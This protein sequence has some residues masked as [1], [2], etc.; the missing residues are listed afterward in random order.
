VGSLSVALHFSPSSAAHC[1]QSANAADGAI[2]DRRIALRRGPPTTRH[3]TLPRTHA[4]PSIAQL[5][6][7]S[8]LFASSQFYPAGVHILRGPVPRLAITPTFWSQQRSFSGFCEDFWSQRRFSD[9]ARIFW[10]LRRFLDSAKIFGYS[11]DFFWILRRFLDPAKIFG[12]SEDFLDSA[13][14]FGY[15]EDFLDPA[16]IFGFSKDFF[17]FWGVTITN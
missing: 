3:L 14:I 1:L 9:T 7:L 13:K 11:E 15:S 12:Y 4:R 8:F 10:I 16:K 6:N 17:Q 2:V 5:K